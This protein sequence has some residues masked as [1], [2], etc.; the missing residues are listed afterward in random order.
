MENDIPIFFYFLIYLMCLVLGKSSYLENAAFNQTLYTMPETD[1][2]KQNMNPQSAIGCQVYDNQDEILYLITSTRAYTYG[3]RCGSTKKYVE[4]L[5]YKVH[6]NTFGDRLLIGKNKVGYPTAVGNL[7]SDKIETCGILKEHNLLYYVGSNIYKCAS[8]YNTDSSIVRINLNTFTFMDRT[9]L[10]NIDNIPAFSESNYYK[11]EY[12]NFPKSSEIIYN[13]SIPRLYLG[14]GGFY[15]G[16]WELDIT[17]TPIILKKSLQMT[18][19]V[20]N[21]DFYGS[22]YISYRTEYFRDITKSIINDKLKMIYFLQDNQYLDG[23]VLGFNY[24][25]PMSVNNTQLYFLNGINKISAF[26]HDPYLEKYYLLSG[27]LS[28]ELYQYD[29]NFQRMNVNP[30]C[31]ID[32]LKLP[33]DWGAINNLWVDYQTGYIYLV[34]NMRYPYYGIV[35]IPSNTLEINQDILYFSQKVTNSKYSYTSY[36]NLNSSSLI[37]SQGKLVIFSGYNSW[38]R[39]YSVVDLAGCAKG[40]GKIL[41][42]CEICPVGTFTNK[43]GSSSCKL[44]QL[45]YSNENKG[46][47]SCK[48]CSSGKFT[49]ILGSGTCNNCLPGF[50][51]NNPGSHNC[52]QCISGKYSITTGSNNRFDCLDC[53]QGRFSLSGETNCK[54][55][56]LGTFSKKG[57]SCEECPN[58]RYSNILGIN[59]AEQC[60]LCSKGKYS[61]KTSLQAESECINCPLGRVGVYAGAKDNTTCIKCNVGKYRNVGMTSCTEC[62]LGKISEEG[63]V[64]C[65]ECVTGKYAD[66]SKCN[67]CI[68]GKYRSL[69]MKKCEICI[70]GRI[71]NADMDNCILCNAGKYASNTKC[72]LCKSGKYSSTGS[73][74]CS[75]CSPGFISKKGNSSCTKCNVG[76]FSDYNLQCVACPK[77]RYSD[78]MEIDNI[79]NCKDCPVGKYNGKLGAS[80]IF[81]CISCLLGKY[82]LVSG[83]KTNMSCINCEAG[84]YRDNSIEDGEECAICKTGQY[85]SESAIFCHDCIQGTYSE[86]SK[87]TDFII[88]KSCPIGTYNMFS[89]TN[90]I[91]GCIKCPAGTW[92]NTLASNSSLHCNPCTYGKYSDVIGANRESSCIVCPSGKYRNS[93]GASSLIDCYSCIPGKYSLSGSKNCK[94]CVSGK[95]SNLPDSIECL[96]C[97]ENTYS[98]TNATITCK[99]CSSS[100]IKNI[101]GDGCQCLSESYQDSNTNESLICNSCPNNFICDGSDKDNLNLESGYWRYSRDTTETI[102]CKHNIMCQGGKI[103]NSTDN[104]CSDGH[105]GPICDVCKNGWA[106]SDGVCFSCQK[107]HGSRNIAFT[108]LIPFMCICILVFLIKTANPSDNKKEEVSGVVKIFVNY[109]QVFSLASSFEINWPIIVRQLF[110]TTKE[111]SSP[112]ISFYSSDCVIGW[113]YYD[114]LLVYLALPLGYII[115]TTLTLVFIS[116][117]YSWKRDIKLKNIVR[118]TDRLQYISKNPDFCTFFGAWAKTAIVVG[119]FLAWHTIIS[120]ALSVISC[121]KIGTKYYLNADLEIE[122]YTQQHYTYLFI[123]YLALFVYGIGIPGAG[124]YMLYK[125]RYHLYEHDKYSGP[126]PLF[127]L[128]LGYRENRWYYE[129]I[130]MA[131]KLGLIIIGV[132]LKNHARYQMIGSSLLIQIAFFFHVFLRPYDNITEYG[133]ICNKLESISLLSLVVTLNTGL[134][135]G[136]IDAGYILGNFE[137][138][139]VIFLFIMNG[140]VIFYFAYYFITLGGKACKT[141]LKEKMVKV[142]LKDEENPKDCCRKCCNPRILDCLVDFSTRENLEDFGI[143]LLNQN[144]KEIFRTYFQQKK[145]KMDLI[146]YKTNSLKKKGLI[147]KMEKLRTRIDIMERDRC[148]A[149]VLNNRVYFKLKKLVMLHKRNLN[150]EKIEILN[151]L[152][153]MYI[154]NGIQYNES[155]A[156]LYLL[157]LE[158]L[159]PEDDIERKMSL[160]S[161]IVR[162]SSKLSNIEMVIENIEEATG[163]EFSES[164]TDSIKRITISIEDNEVEHSIVI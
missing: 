109:A 97:S 9:I 138:V 122:C 41:E 146:K 6:N 25:L 62:D 75:Q 148:W 12:I 156:K 108:I 18:Y 87:S 58:G 23:I 154:K 100:S 144:E 91:E 158:D 78:V 93:L 49:N 114:K 132:F 57:V 43:I 81:E 160:S 134:F 46:S 19:Q 44:C 104:L 68:A 66:I 133:I 106:K 89:G 35:K 153:E 32:F 88:C 139:L 77:G 151:E 164:S 131:K 129:F 30:Q 5:K 143:E 42:T 162:E 13:N 55:C 26:Q 125:H 27:S 38:H 147:L 142:L 163:I 83:A 127:F 121:R 3:D 92:S 51:S 72:I 34:I 48:K 22:G 79:H 130:V 31:G 150:D 76:K 73:I 90:T 69:G 50:F 33:T 161:Y 120:Y 113:K 112:R 85:S 64:K 111:F 152:F 54:V 141:H 135:F 37:L 28:S 36:F 63:R 52:S 8:S 11:Y 140:L 96:E 70:S 60:K 29:Y 20:Q 67:K 61:T 39:K 16:I 47:E 45:G 117:I 115:I 21:Q 157:E 74:A 99:S 102:K 149:T 80:S 124:Y 103:I 56:E 98:D 94:H 14:F 7:G 128:Y 65:E 15:T 95:Y 59:Y 118:R 107:Y 82:S 159:I 155:M 71:P 2:I 105:K 119:T 116:F 86:G 126:S 137:T 101:Q 145:E 53:E 40:R 110:E 136:T 123:S 4:V 10:R 84:K 24:T 17:K 1:I